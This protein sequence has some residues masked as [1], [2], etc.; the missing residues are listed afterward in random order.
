MPLSP[1]RH[2]IATATALLVILVGSGA[3]IGWRFDVAVLTTVVP[4]WPS[5]KVNTA[6]ALVLAGVSLWIS[7]SSGAGY[8]TRLVGAAC[9]VVVCLIATLTLAEYL[10]GRDLGI[11][12]IFIQD[13]TTIWSP[14]RPGVNSAF[15]FFVLSFA[16]MF[17]SSRQLSPWLRESFGLMVMVG[18]SIV[19]LGYLYSAAELTNDASPTQMALHT[20]LAFL[21]L[22]TG[23]LVRDDSGPVMTVL[24]SPG[25]GGSLARK[26]L[27]R[28]IVALVLIGALRL[29]GERMGWYGLELGLSLLV[30]MSSI[31][32]TLVTLRYARST[33]DAQVGRMEAERRVRDAFAQVRTLA[34]TAER[35]REA[36]RT[37]IAREIH[38]EL[39]QALTGVKMDLAWV[40]SRLPQDRAIQER[41]D[42]MGELLEDA[43]QIGRRISSDLRPGVLDDLGLV[44]ALQWQAREFTKR[45]G[46]AVRIDAPGDVPVP[47]ERATAAFR[48]CQEALTNIS[49]HSAATR[50]QVEVVPHDH[51]LT[52]VIQDNGRGFD[53]DAAK[54]GS[55]GL[56]GM[57]ER[58]EAWGGRVR[59]ES[60]VGAG[61]TVT[62]ELPLG[63]VLS[64]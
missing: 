58:A 37:R 7:V 1:R 33:D 55:F 43:V 21:A 26:L 22:A 12:Q 56:L 20:A 54:A 50:V 8:R 51:S 38:D 25:P 45:T 3:L 32:T 59:V 35:S 48:I 23:V 62:L 41:F 30:L 18:A 13:P 47:D 63:E 36:E 2:Q 40:R 24:T 10:L 9:A 17:G 34:A 16:L 15:Q 27:P 19:L 49:R 42:A 60:T 31:V 64:T 46:I 29:A 52:V 5:M 39:G 61:T 14:G 53:A 44:A 4:G 57:Q 28:L 6:L 11:D